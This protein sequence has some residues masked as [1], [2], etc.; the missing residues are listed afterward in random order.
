[1]EHKNE[2]NQPL[3]MLWVQKLGIMMRYLVNMIYWA[4]YGAKAQGGT[5][6][7]TSL[8]QDVPSRKSMCA[9]FQISYKLHISLYFL[10]VMDGSQSLCVKLEEFILEIGIHTNA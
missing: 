7:R 10:S 3:F 1:M 6:L 2:E 5:I 9:L 4:E 8:E